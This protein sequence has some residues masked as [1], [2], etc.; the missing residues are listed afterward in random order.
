MT[1]NIFGHEQAVEILKSHIS[2]DQLRHAY[3]FTGPSGVGRRTLALRF[4]QAI[5]CS[6]PPSVGIPCMQ[7]RTCT[8]LEQMQHP[9]L[10]VVQAE[11]IGEIL[12]IDQIREL[13]HILALSPYEA[14]YRIAL[15]LRFEEAHISAA[16][17]ILKTLEEPP[18]KVIFLLTADTLESLPATI[19][20][21]CETIRLMPAPRSQISQAL[22]N[23]TNIDSQHAQLIAS[24]SNGCY[25]LAMRMIQFPD[26][27][28][29]RQDWINEF[30]ELLHS[31]LV[32]RF[33]SAET[34][35]QEKSSLLS[36]L[37]SWIAFW[38]DV[39][40]STIKADFQPA[41]L[42]YQVE[43][44]KIASTIDSKIIFKSL[45][46]LRQTYNLVSRNINPRLA[47]E[48]LML[49]LPFL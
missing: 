46:A 8:L 31:S 4:A 49:D 25:G 34:F 15:L 45:L 7:C 41:N 32:K 23:L 10:A 16:N 28:K 11:Q 18:G 21:R 26:I 29:Q 38:R 13:Q 22:S 39:M 20:S 27:F 1:W 5:N 33:A 36:I 24:L 2:S 9:D 42:D 30:L 19:V 14:R 47:L 40:L 35:A 44:Q 17:A 3:L 37:S 43:I 6:Q 12:K 48:T